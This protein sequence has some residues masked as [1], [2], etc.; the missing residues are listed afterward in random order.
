MLEGNAY[1]EGQEIIVLPVSEMIRQGIACMPQK[2]NV[3]EEF[4][5]EENWLALVAIYLKSRTKERV[6]SVH[7]MLPMLKAMRCGHRFT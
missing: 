1:F 3:F 6:Q 4:T 7:E 5:V 2:K